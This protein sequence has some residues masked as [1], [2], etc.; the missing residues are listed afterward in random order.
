MTNKETVDLLPCPFCGA[1]KA[2]PFSRTCELHSKYDPADR[3]YPVVRCHGCFV[4]VA[5][6]DWTPID[7]AIAAWNT[8]TPLTCISQEERIAELEAQDEL[9]RERLFVLSDRLRPYLHDDAMFAAYSGVV[10]A[11]TNTGEPA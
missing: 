11:L 9:I 8:R 6:K 5:G 1:S 3:A 4:E 7:T 2:V 10:A